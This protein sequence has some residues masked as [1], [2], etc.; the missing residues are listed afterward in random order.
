MDTIEKNK[1]ICKYGV[2]TK[3]SDG[4]PLCGDCIY[5]PF[6]ETW[7]KLQCAGCESRLFCER[8]RRDT[9]TER[10]TNITDDY[11]LTQGE[12]F[13]EFF[14]NNGE[15]VTIFYDGVWEYTDCFKEDSS[16]MGTYGI[17]DA[18]EAIIECFEGQPQDRAKEAVKAALVA[19]GYAKA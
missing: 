6:V 17:T 18:K 19:L 3:F 1:L 7:H 8:I 12:N 16:E 15:F 11:T 10:I 13:A 14:R 2:C 9:K 5:K 4:Q